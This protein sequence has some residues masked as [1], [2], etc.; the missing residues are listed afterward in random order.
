MPLAA[1]ALKLLD[2]VAG[3]PAA[4]ALG[5]LLRQRRPRPVPEGAPR[6]VL[7]IRPGG[8]GDAVLFIPLLRELRRAWPAAEIDLLM[9]RRN[10]GIV[11]GTDLAR[12]VILYDRGPGA[13]LGALRGGYDLVIDTEQYHALSAM[14]AVLTGAPRRIG[15]GTNVRRELFTLDVPYD[16]DTYEVESFLDLA[17]AATGRE[18][19]WDPDRAFFP[20]AAEAPSIAGRLLAPL[21]GRPV[22]AL[23]PGASI[24]ERQWP[25]ER[26]AELAA[27]LAAHGCGI[28]LLGGRVDRAATRQI[29]AAVAEPGAVVD[30][31]GATSLA[32]VAAVIAHVAAYVSSDTGLLHIAYSVGTPTVHLFGP[33]VLSKWGPP[34]AKYTTLAARVPCSPCT[35]YGYTPPCNQG[36]ICM[37]RIGVE[38]VRAAGLAKLGGGND[39]CGGGVAEDRS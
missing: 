20:L 3:R 4:G 34:G 12:R 9:E 38:Q 35:I 26:Y 33:G 28:A 32:E 29:A 18:P 31:A 23:N 36:M 5:W 16:H 1:H 13:L 22:V 25:V 14:I 2:L 19:A 30:L 21:T 6:R 17:R 7:V 37:T 24:P 11:A 8:I 39:S 15:F 10:A 27:T